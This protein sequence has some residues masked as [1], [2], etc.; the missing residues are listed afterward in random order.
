MNFIGGKVKHR[1][2]GQGVIVE[3]KDRYVSV[4]FNGVIK[5]FLIE[6]LETFFSFEDE[7][8]RNAA[9]EAA[10]D[11]KEKKQSQK[12]TEE[13]TKEELKTVTTQSLFHNDGIKYEHVI[14]FLEPV[15]VYLNSVNKKDRK[16]VLEIFDACDKETQ[17]LYKTFEPK[18]IYP[19]FTSHSR[20]KYCVGYLTKHLGVYVFRVFS[21]NDVYKKRVRSGITVMESYTAE[22]FRAL[23]INGK[24]YYF[25]KSEYYF[26]TDR[27]PKWHGSKSV[28]NVLLNRVACNC[29]CGYLNGYV[30]D[31]NLNIEAFKYV[32]LLLLA[33]VNNKAEIVFKN[34]G[35][36]STAA[37]SNLADYLEEFSPKQIEFASK[38]D[39]INS[40]PVIKNLGLYDVPILKEMEKIM[41]ER[42]WYGSIYNINVNLTGIV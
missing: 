17:T 19:E 10:N 35:F 3:V 6:T 32:R 42:G 36:A 2:F 34:K 13:K 39:V 40:L 14:T 9:R 26:N 31:N 22:V 12:I 30:A 33:L 38:N 5:T 24:F 29:D 4:D 28:T 18:M 41:R 20:S 27:L 25:S 16:L 7:N 21:R 23:Q 15:P 1:K 37:I 8:V 11:I